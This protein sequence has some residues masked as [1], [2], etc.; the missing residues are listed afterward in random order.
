MRILSLVLAAILLAPAQID[1]KTPKWGTF[2]FP[3]VELPLRIE[4]LVEPHRR[5]SHLE[6]AHDVEFAFAHVEP[7]QV[8]PQQHQVVHVQQ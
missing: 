1:A 7:E 2:V 8:Q 6:V 3:H 4:P 5:K